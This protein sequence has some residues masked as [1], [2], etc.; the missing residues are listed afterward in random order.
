MRGRPPDACHAT[1]LCRARSA[2]A[3]HARRLRSRAGGRRRPGARLATTS[4]SRP[5]DLGGRAGR[6]RLRGRSRWHAM[7]PPLGRQQ[8]RWTR[9]PAVTRLARRDRR[10]RRSWSGTTTSAAK[11]CSRRSGCGMPAVL[12]VNAPIVDYPGSAKARLDRALLVEPMR[13]WRDRL[14]RHDRSLRDADRGHPA[15]VDRSRTAC[16]RSNGAPTS[17]TSGRTRTGPLPVRARSESHSVRVR[18]RV[19]IVARRRAPVGGAGPPARGGR[20]A[21]RR[22]ASSAT[23]PSARRPNAPRADV[24]GVTFTGALP[25]DRLPAVLAAAD[26]G[27]A[28]FDPVQH[29]PLRL[30]FYWSPLKIFEYMAAG[31]PVVAPALPRLGTAGRARTRR[32]ALRSGRSARARPRRW[33]RS[34]TRASAGGWARRRATRVVRDFSWEAH[35]AA[36]DARLAPAGHHDE[37]PA[38]RPA[39]HR[40]VSAVCGGSG[41][42]TWELARGLAA[43]GHHVE[44]VKIE[45]GM[46]TRR[47]SNATYESFR[48]TTF[49]R[50][51][52]GRAGRPQRRQERAAVGA[53]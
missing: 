43:R 9:R 25:H 48:V 19:P 20:H 26:I 38:A 35:C 28:P 11:A 32:S 14:C 47:L 34:P 13:R 42:S 33:W 39:R 46:R 23:A 41:W 31:L 12:E 22:R 18:G 45:I 10:G 3:G 2:G 53:T 37:R 1:A 29:A 4:T 44:V 50:H 6:R 49:R 51:G 5:T 15:G 21:I 24:P 17:S 52:A 16:S 30:G 27:V 8:L 7:A 40:F 36:L